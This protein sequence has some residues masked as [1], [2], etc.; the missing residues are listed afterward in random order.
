MIGSKW[1][2]SI[3]CSCGSIGFFS[4]CR[5]QPQYTDRHAA[6]LFAPRVC[7]LRASGPAYHGRPLSRGLRFFRPPRRRRCPGYEH[8]DPVRGFPRFG[9][10]PLLRSHGHVWHF[11]LFPPAGDPL[12]SM[13]AFFAAI[14]MAIVPYARARAEAASIT[15]SNGILESPKGSSFFQ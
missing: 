11:H 12:S 1:S 3:R 5:H 10:R 4:K 6:L 15:C 13:V 7:S 9:S 14:G 2:G 8:G